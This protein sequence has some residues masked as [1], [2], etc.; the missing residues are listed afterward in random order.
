MFKQTQREN[1]CQLGVWVGIPAVYQ[2]VKKAS[3]RTKET[4]PLQNGVLHVHVRHALNI[5]ELQ[6]PLQL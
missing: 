1:A 2:F 4:Q 5:I 6:Q 3:R